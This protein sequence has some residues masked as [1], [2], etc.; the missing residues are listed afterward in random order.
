MN[1]I[2][3]DVI[4]RALWLLLILIAIL[5][6]FIYVYRRVFFPV[7][8]SLIIAYLVSPLVNWM[9]NKIKI[10]RMLCV[11]LIV[12]MLLGLIFVL[13]LLLYPI[14]INQIYLI[15]QLIPEVK[16]NSLNY[17]LEFIK[18]IEDKIAVDLSTYINLDFVKSNVFSLVNHIPQIF[19]QLL[20]KTT[21][22]L[23]FFVDLILIL[24]MTIFLLIN[25]LKFHTYINSIIPSDLRDFFYMIGYKIDFALKAAI[26]GQIIVACIV[27]CLYMSGLAIV[28]LKAGL[29]I[30]FIMGVCR[31]V[32][33]L[34]LIVGIMLS[35]IVMIAY[36]ANLSSFV[37]WGTVIVITAVQ[38]LDG[39]FIAPR[40]LGSKIGLHPV[41]II[42]SLVAFA[43]RWGFWGVLMTVPV[44]AIIKVLITIIL[45]F[46]FASEWFNKNSNVNAN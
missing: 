1:N 25:S 13:V 21:N 15:I 3:F 19:L 22:V 37:F 44:L 8:I 23:N 40:I 4:K 28:G 5:S 27:G 43:Y 33:Y 7:V 30:G 2:K 14:I 41:I 16:N 36:W 24:M 35:A 34:E 20:S 10:S 45:E 29:A 11:I 38:C 31:V 39:L 46:Y 6:V 26:R 9:N 18:F 17:F 42:I 32:P 12:L